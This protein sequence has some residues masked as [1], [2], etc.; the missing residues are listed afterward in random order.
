MPR[1]HAPWYRRPDEQQKLAVAALLALLALIAAAAMVIWQSVIPKAFFVLFTA[2]LIGIATWL[3]SHIKRSHLPALFGG[4][5]FVGAAVIL[6]VLLFRQ[7]PAPKSANPPTLSDL[8]NA[9]IKAAH[10][11]ILAGA[12]QLNLG[13]GPKPHTFGVL[14]LPFGVRYDIDSNTK[15][16][17]FYVGHSPKPAAVIR[18]IASHYEAMMS[19]AA[20]QLRAQYL[21]SG[22]QSDP[23]D[24]Q[25]SR[26][27]GT[28]YVYHIDFLTAEQVSGVNKAFGQ[29]GAA[30]NLRGPEYVTQV[31]EA[32]RAGDS[33]PLPTFSQEPYSRV[34]CSN[35]FQSFPLL[36]H[37]SLTFVCKRPV[38]VPFK[39]GVL[40]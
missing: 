3:W 14:W 31:Y 29:Y 19:V 12:Y 24:T 34:D 33:T 9:D 38:A 1:D 5:S 2:A 11:L 13:P 15:D 37:S 40:R 7:P 8:F 26:F 39:Q 30:V 21:A 25:R 32:I 16:I 35:S 23:R 28:V 18:W 4:L 22:S 27:T 10:G 17:W 6:T 36:P 20:K